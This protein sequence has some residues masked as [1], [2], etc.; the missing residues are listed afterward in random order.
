MAASATKTNTVKFG[1]GTPQRFM[2]FGVIT[3]DS[4]ATVEV[5]TQLAF[6]E[7]WDFSEAVSGGALD[8]PTLDETFTEAAPRVTVD[9][10]GQVTVDTAANSTRVF[11]YKFIGF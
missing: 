8:L 1:S 9:A 11:V 4:D 5:D 6:I 10:D 3:F 7:N 2:E